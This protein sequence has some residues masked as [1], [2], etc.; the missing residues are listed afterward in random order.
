MEDGNFVSCQFKPFMKALMNKEVLSVNDI[1]DWLSA[2]LQKYFAI[3]DEEA[4][5]CTLYVGIAGA[6]GSSLLMLQLESTWLKI[7][8]PV[9]KVA[10]KIDS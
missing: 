2:L 6:G 7:V 3:H 10:V 1:P 9:L 8:R 5:L 4:V